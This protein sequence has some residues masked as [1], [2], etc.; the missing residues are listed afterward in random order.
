MNILLGVTGSV[1]ATLTPK[2]VQGFQVCDHTVQ[3][4]ATQSSKYFFSP[5]SLGVKVWLDG[6]EWLGVEYQ[7]GQH[8]AHIDLTKW[9]DVLVIAPLSANTMAKLANGLCDN[10]PT[11][12]FGA[13]DQT[14]PVVLAPAMNS[15]MWTN[16][17]TRRHM[18]A[19]SE[20]V[21]YGLRLKFASP[22]EKTLACCDT[23]IGAMAEIHTII[24]TVT[25]FS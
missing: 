7:K 16:P 19:L 12:V 25:S 6:Y 22:I 21:T 1:A 15:N 3:V 23:G 11:C 14:K 20:L 4:V 5:S 13:W 10:L 17:V 24:D 18:Q 2:L 8:I 9:A